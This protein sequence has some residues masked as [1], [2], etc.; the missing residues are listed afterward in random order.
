MDFGWRFHL[1]SCSDMGIDFNFGSGSTFAKTGE[2]VGA[3]KPDFDDSWWRNVDLPHD[4]AI[5]LDFDPRADRYHGYK[6][7]GRKWPHNTIGWYRKTFHLSKSDEGRRIW[8]EFDGIFR[9]SMVWLNGHFLGRHMSGYTSF[10]YDIT[11][12]VNY[13]GENV[14]VVRVDASHFEGWWYEGAGIYRHVWLV[15]TDP[16][17]IARWGTFIASYVRKEAGTL[18]GEL[19][20]KTRIVNECKKDALCQLVSTILDAE[21]NV[22]GECKSKDIAI[23]AWEKKE[24]VQKIALRNPNLWSVNSPYLYTLVQNVKEKDEVVDTYKTAFGIRTIRFDP[25]K[26]FFLNGEP[27]RIKGVCIHQDFAGVGIALPDRIHEFRIK[28][29]KDMGCNAIRCAHNPPAPEFLDACDRLGMLVV[30]ENRMM[31]SSPEALSQLKSMVLR[32]RNHPSVILWCL[33]NEEHVI[34]G[35]DTGARIVS[36]MKHL[37][38]RLDPTRPVTVAM[39]G[40]WGSP[41][42]LVC[43]VQGCNYIRCGDID[44]YHKEH[45]NHPMIATETGSTL[46][47]R[48]V[49]TNDEKRGYVNAYGTTL[50][51]WGS[52]PE[53]MWKFFAERPFVAGVFVWSGFDYLGEPLPYGWPCVG[54]NFGIMDRCGFPKDI[55]YYYKSWWSGETVL[56]IFPHWNW[57]GREGQEIDV[58]CFSNCDEVELLLNGKSLGRKKMQR[59]SHLEWKVKY[60]PGT[61]EAIGYRN[62]EE[63]AKT[64]V[65]TTDPPAGLRL[66]PDRLKI[67]ADNRDVSIVTVAVVDSKGRIVPTANNLIEFRVTGRG[68]IIGVDNGDPSSHEPSKARRRRAFNGLCMVIIQSTL[69]PGL[70]KLTAESE[71]LNP[72]T[73]VIHSEK[74][75]LV[76]FIP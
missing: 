26:G 29:L 62:G 41:V 35:T 4:W 30:D 13:G 68:K 39:N 1:G 37:V 72:A 45:P 27:L 38:K 7:I 46:S 67:R 54:S 9:D 53:E 42:S 21:G 50:P 61:L 24:V 73:I 63:V 20:I 40:D 34:Q 32:D 69:E 12:Y 2:A 15:K 55:Y 76:P 64:K 56:H 74:C 8:I 22:V 23:K 14:L 18:I 65:E 33:G 6:P 3:V 36:T 60:E 11:D 31:G 58:W 52:T 19:T 5:E 47:T 43:D 59:Y 44:R 48:G 28:K 71:G 51:S 25:E 10:H 70:I 66:M 17:H 16:L 49:Y 75:S 57:P